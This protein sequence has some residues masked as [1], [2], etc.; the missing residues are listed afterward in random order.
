MKRTKYSPEVK[1]RSVRLV[2]ESHAGHGSQWATIESVSSKIG[3]S[4][5]TLCNWV[6]QYERD[7][8]QRESMS[9]VEM[10]R[11]KELEREV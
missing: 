7:T 6:R 4:A 9:S 1:E 11:L 10:A 5:Q 2:F 8:G 3:C